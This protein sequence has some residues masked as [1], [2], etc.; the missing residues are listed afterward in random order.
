MDDKN[1]VV[2]TILRAAGAEK[3]VKDFKEHH[4]DLSYLKL[5]SDEDLR[6][7]GVDNADTRNNILKNCAN[8]QMHI[9]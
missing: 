7:I 9:E 1:E 6:I 3:Y 5:L 4:I 2:T 8:L